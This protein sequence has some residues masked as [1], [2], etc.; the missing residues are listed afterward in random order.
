M[1]YNQKRYE[2][3][4]K[5]F[6]HSHTYYT[7]NKKEYK[8]NNKECLIMTKEQKISALKNRI[9]LLAGRKGIANTSIVNKINRQ[10][11]KLERE[12]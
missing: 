4:I 8:K 5:K 1:D 7:L 9:N 3:E 6:L 2:R 12:A 11:R 10:I